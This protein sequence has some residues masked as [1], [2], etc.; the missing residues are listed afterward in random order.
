MASISKEYDRISMMKLHHIPFI[1]VSSLK[2]HGQ[3]PVSNSS[4]G[5]GRGNVGGGPKF[6]T[7]RGRGMKNKENFEISSMKF[8]MESW[9][10]NQNA[11]INL[12]RGTKILSNIPE[13]LPSPLK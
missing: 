8:L 4:R 12:R 2:A 3:G 5:G 10:D 9:S 6:C 13:C 1:P 11:C 7:L